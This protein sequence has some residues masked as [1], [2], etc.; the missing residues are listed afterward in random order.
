MTPPHTRPRRF[1][2][3]LLVGRG[4]RVT[5]AFLLREIDRLLAA[6]EAEPGLLARPVRVVV[7]SRSLRLHLGTAVARHRGRSAAGLLIQTHYHLALEVIERAGETL[8]PGRWLAELLPERRARSREALAGPLEELVDGFAAVVATVRDLHD[9]R[10]EPA[11]FEGIDEALATDGPTVATR[12]QVARARALLEVA[13]ETHHEIDSKGLGSTAR[14]LTRAAE[15]LESRG[16]TLLPSRAVLLHGYADATGVVTDLLQ[17]LQRRFGAWVLLD[18][19]PDPARAAEEARQ[20]T[21]LGGA[22]GRFGEELVERL[23]QAASPEPIPEG[24][25]P[26]GSLQPEIEVFTAHGAEGEVREVAERIAALHSRS[27]PEGIAVVARDPTPY[28]RE[29]RRR[30]RLLGLPFSALGEGGAPTPEQRRARALLDLLRRGH[31]TPTER[32]I[33]ALERLAGDDGK[34][35]GGRALMDLRLGLAA[36]GAG[37]LGDVARLNVAQVLG[38]RTSLPLPVRQGISGV[39]AGSD[40]A[41][42]VDEPDIDEPDDGTGDGT[43]PTTVETPVRLLRRTLGRSVLDAAVTAARRLGTRLDRWPRKAPPEDHRGHLRRLVVEEL[44]WRLESPE[45]AESSGASS[46]GSSPLLDALATLDAEAPEGFEIGFD[47]V[48]RLLARILD[49]RPGSPL[50]GRGGGVQVLS[51]TEARGRTFDHLF[52][53]GCNRGVFPRPVREDPLL[54]DELRRVLQRV[55]PDMPVK[56]RG[57]D[58]E[59]YLFAQLLSSSPRVTLSWQ[60]L[61]DTGAVRPASPLVE[62]L[63]LSPR[64]AD[65]TRDE[66]PAGAS[67]HEPVKAQAAWALPVRPAILRPAVEAATLVALHGPRNAFR[68]VLPH[69]VRI[70]ARESSVSPERLTAARLALLDEVDP[71]LSTPEGRV[72]ATRLGPFFGFVGSPI[73]PDPRHRDLWVTTVERL[74]GCPW[75]VFLTRLLGLEP[76]PDPLAALPGIDPLLLG[77]VVHGAL[78]ELVGLPED[79]PGRRSSVEELRS[80]SEVRPPWPDGEELDERITAAAG[81]VLREEGLALPG[82]TR[83]LSRA[84]RPYLDAAREEDWAA[85]PP[86]VVGVETVGE[87]MVRDADGGERLLRFRA[88]RVDRERVGGEGS[89]RDSLVFTDYKTGRP[90]RGSGGNEGKQERTRRRYL[91]K[92]VRAGTRLQAVAYALADHDRSEGPGEGNAVGRYLFLRPDTEY[93]NRAVGP[94]DEDF[95][96]DFVAAFDDAVSAGLGV[97]DVGAFFPRVVDPSGEDEPTRCSWCPVAEACVRGDSGARLRLVEGSR[98]AGGSTGDA[99]G[100][101]LHTLWWLGKEPPSTR[102]DGD[103]EDGS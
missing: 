20:R 34:V 86:P 17:A 52:L 8:R 11:L 80:R 70:A 45:G 79:H 92:D 97:W 84:A 102:S 55:L 54:P 69:A 38:D 16:E 36:V 23:S 98:R 71:D 42:D 2:P 19:P 1:Q 28:R 68:E 27:R 50:G 72:A 57:F 9:A 93:R 33:E 53:L 64:A 101:A 37:R 26:E 77:R 59:R 99:A 40:D 25:S 5:E 24:I 18:R 67:W 58:E 103:P 82:L 12:R 100:A 39:A 60:H 81:K 15:L 95:Q 6:A 65:G 10:F 61:D 88:D 22:A 87:V 89:E 13:R 35:F 43:A 30:F 3:R 31:R 41:P 85:G 47:E 66:P 44:G 21:G 73:E 4:T 51:V 56:T 78:E 74:A 48:Q 14:L 62:R 75:Q 96:R 32:W 91:L 63:R 46:G 76:T 90:P 7:P 94:G 29:I 49:A 83:A